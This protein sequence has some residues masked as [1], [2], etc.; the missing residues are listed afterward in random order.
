M[1]RV[2]APLEPR[3]KKVVQK[4]VSPQAGRLLGNAQDGQAARVEK[5]RQVA[6]RVLLHVPHSALK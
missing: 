3:F 2:D 6:R 1:D 4:T 5:P